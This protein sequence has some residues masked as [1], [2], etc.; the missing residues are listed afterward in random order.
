MFTWLK[1]YFNGAYWAQCGK[2][3]MDRRKVH[4]VRSSVS[5]PKR[6]RAAQSFIPDPPT[7]WEKKIEDACDPR[8]P[9]EIARLIETGVRGALPPGF[10]T[11]QQL[12]R[13]IEEAQQIAVDNARRKTSPFNLSYE[14]S[15]FLA[16]KGIHL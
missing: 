11:K 13:I 2:P 4:H 9:V 6:P 14:L 1:K 15:E 7:P 3:V 16:S 10:K 12:E 8:N 5:N